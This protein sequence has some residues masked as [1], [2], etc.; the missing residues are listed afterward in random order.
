MR[1]PSQRYGAGCVSNKLGAMEPRCCAR[2]GRPLPP[3]KPIGRP[4]R[5]CSDRCRYA[6]PGAIEGRAYAWAAVSYDEMIADFARSYEEL[7]EQLR[8][9]SSERVVGLAILRQRH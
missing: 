4:R 9:R 8:D 5:F 2:C 6:G 7:L 3:H 1:P